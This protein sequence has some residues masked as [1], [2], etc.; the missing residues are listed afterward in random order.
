MIAPSPG[1]SGDGAVSWMTVG[2]PSLS[3]PPKPISVR[4]APVGVTL[5]VFADEN[6]ES[7]ARA[8]VA[9]V[10]QLVQANDLGFDVALC[11][12]GSGRNRNTEQRAQN[13]CRG[14]E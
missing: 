7:D 2:N 12:G 8:P 14:Q 3:F 9:L 10:A 11:A 5:A 6:A 1:H 13:S 4:P